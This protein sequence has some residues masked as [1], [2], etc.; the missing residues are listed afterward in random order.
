M[1][2]NLYNSSNPEQSLTDNPQ[3]WSAGL[4]LG[5]AG[6]TVGGSVAEQN[7]V[8]LSRHI[9]DTGIGTRPL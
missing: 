4:N 1:S 2:A 6:F 8:V 7:N 3:I 5:Y 9:A